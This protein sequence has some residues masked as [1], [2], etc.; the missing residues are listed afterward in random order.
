MNK[1]CIIINRLDS[2]AVS[3]DSYVYLLTN[4]L[5]ISIVAILHLNLENP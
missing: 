4:S 1:S 5:I 3:P 2:S